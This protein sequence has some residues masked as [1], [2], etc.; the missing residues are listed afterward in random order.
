MN[1]FTKRISK[2]TKNQNACLV[3]GSAFGNLSEILPIFETVFVH[4]NEGNTIKS[5]NLVFLENILDLSILPPVGLILIDLEYLG[6]LPELR[7]IW[8]KFSPTIMIG[9]GEFI[10]KDWNKFLNNHRYQIV[11]LYK[12]YQVW[13]MK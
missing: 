11:E 9:S 10:S 3:F 13:K 12:D 5:R 6:N 7:Q 4:S 8:T 1:K 2:T